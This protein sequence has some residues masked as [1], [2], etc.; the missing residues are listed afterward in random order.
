MTSI[1]ELRRMALVDGRGRGLAGQRIRAVAKATRLTPKAL[2]ERVATKLG[3][4]E[5]ETIAERIAVRWWEKVIE[6]TNAVWEEWHAEF[7]EQSQD[8]VR[9]ANEKR[10]RKGAQR[11]ATTK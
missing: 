4:G 2:A 6:A 7:V 5:P 10:A 1:P 8:R 9:R 3:G 11:V